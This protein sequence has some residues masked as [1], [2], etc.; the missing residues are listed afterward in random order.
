MSVVSAQGTYVTF[1]G[2]S[3][4]KVVSVDG[5]FKSATKEIR[6]LAPNLDVSTG[7]YLS[8][9]EPTVCEQTVKIDSLASADAVTSAIVGSKQELVITGTGW[10]ISFPAAICESFTISAKLGD[11]V[12]FSCA[13]KRTYY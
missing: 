1:G 5:D 3:L 11:V 12:R 9:F 6:A 2:A 7:Q 8:I 10:S 13:F 4:G